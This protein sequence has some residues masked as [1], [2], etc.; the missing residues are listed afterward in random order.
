MTIADAQVR[1]FERYGY[2]F[3]KQLLA[4]TVDGITRDPK[5]YSEALEM[6]KATLLKRLDFLDEHLKDLYAFTF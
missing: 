6:L 2:V 3:E 1:N 4:Q 5:S